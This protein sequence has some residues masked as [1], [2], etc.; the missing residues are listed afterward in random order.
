MFCCKLLSEQKW[1]VLFANFEMLLYCCVMCVGVSR[2]F[3]S[4]VEALKV[5]NNTRV[6]SWALMS[7]IETLTYTLHEGSFNNKKCL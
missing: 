2:S 6:S 5:C 3:E 7:G 4:G 1:D